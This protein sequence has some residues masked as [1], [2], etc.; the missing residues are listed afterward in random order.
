[1]VIIG[2]DYH[3]SDQ[4]IAFVDPETGEC[5]ERRL[6]QVPIRSEPTPGF[7]AGERR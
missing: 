2:V 6:V 3:P 1:M 7:L 4:Y 5:G